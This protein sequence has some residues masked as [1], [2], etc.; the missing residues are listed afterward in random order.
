MKTK[1]FLVSLIMIFA[2]NSGAFTISAQTISF[3]EKLQVLLEKNDIEGAIK[4]YDNIPENL[5]EDTDLKLLHASLLI[6]VHRLNE[7][8]AII[9]SLKES[10]NNSKDVLE[11]DAT[12]AVASGNKGAIN[13]AVNA[14]I[15]SDPYNAVA[16]NILGNQQALKKKYKTALGYYK[17]AL[18]RDKTNEEALFGCGQMNYYIGNLQDSKTYFE[19]LLKLRPDESQAYLYLGKLEAENESYLEAIKYVKQ[20]IKLNPNNSDYWIDLGQYQRSSGKFDEAEKSWSKAI[21]LDPD[22]FLGYTYRAGLYDEQ[23][24]IEE[25]LKD[26]H[27]IVETNPKYYFAFEEIGILEFHMENWAVAREYFM[28]ANSINP[29]IAYQLMVLATFLKEKNTFEAK[30][31]ADIF[32]KEG[33]KKDMN[34]SKTQDYNLLRLYKDQGPVMLE[35]TIAKELEKEQNKNKRGKLMYYFGLYYEIKNHPEIAAEYYNK[36]TNMQSPMFYEYRLAEWGIK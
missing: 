32:I 28:K 30:K 23:N 10:G 14:L 3:A 8:S 26:Y 4:L 12:I 20:A 19:L 34:F 22:Y 13:S 24:R 1:V 35:N 16:N 5:A 17:K 33:N 11:M 25:A 36:I 2:I 18:I 9:K 7:A 21:E 27:K 15:S 6:S 31:Y 29:S